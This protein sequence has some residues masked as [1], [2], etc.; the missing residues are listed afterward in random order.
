M[1]AFLSNETDV[2]QR[3]WFPAGHA[4]D[5]TLEWIDSS[6]IFSTEYTEVGCIEEMTGTAS[7]VRVEPASA[8]ARLLW[9]YV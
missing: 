1:D 9:T 8:P 7:P 3:R 5:K 2:F 6:Q 4:S